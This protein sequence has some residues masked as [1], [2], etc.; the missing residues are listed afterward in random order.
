MAGGPAEPG[1]KEYEKKSR[2]RL[3]I[4]GRRACVI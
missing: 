4:A 1:A 3:S 2:H